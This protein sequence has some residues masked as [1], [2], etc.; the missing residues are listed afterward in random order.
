LRQVAAEPRFTAVVGRHGTRMLTDGS[1]RGQEQAAILVA[2]VRYQKAAGLLVEKLTASRGEVSL[3]A[4]WGLRELAV[5]DTLPA[6]LEFFESPRGERPGFQNPG[7]KSEALIRAVDLQ[8]SQLAQFLGQS[9]YRPAEPALRRLVPR[10]TGPWLNSETRAAAIWALGLIHEAKADPEL[11][12]A[13][14][15]RLRDMGSPPLGP[16]NPRVQAMAAVALGRMKAKSALPT[17]RSYWSGKL[18]LDPVQ[19]ACGWAIEQITGEVVP[20]AGT[21]EVPARDW[22]L[23]P[24]PHEKP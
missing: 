13:L 12:R 20:P 1:W 5:P 10:P 21:I 6:V 4:A 19:N 3:A 18:T 17:L 22:F 9:R 2:Q 7:G 15:D 24:L 11:V 8:L 23:T 14:E 16:E